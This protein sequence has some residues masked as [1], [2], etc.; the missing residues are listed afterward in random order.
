MDIRLI[1]GL[2]LGLSAL[3]C[4]HFNQCSTN[5]DCPQV[6][7]NMLYCTPDNICAAGTPA[8]SLCT[9]VYPPNSP[10]N[11]IVIG[12]LINTIS[13]NDQL[14]LLAFEEGIDEVNAVLPAGAQPL[15]L[16]ICEV[17]ATPDDPYKSMEVLALQQN[18]VAAVGPT[19]SSL[20]L[21]IESEVVT[22]GIPIMSPSATSPDISSYGTVNG[23]VNGLF[24]RVAPS[25]ALQGP[26]LAHQLPM[27]FPTTDKLAEMNVDDSYGTGLSS[28]FI[29]AFGTPAL[30]QTYEEPS[31][32]VRDPTTAIAAANAIISSSPNYVVAITNTYSD[33]VVEALVNLPTTIPIIMADG[34]LNQSVLN[35]IGTSGTA[36]FSSYTPTQMNNSLGR[37]TGTAPTTDFNNLTGT[38]AY[39]NF[40]ANFMAKWNMDPTD[41]IYTAYA[42]DAIYAVAIAIGAA[43]SNL[44]PA[45]VSGMLSHINE[46]N[47]ST[48]AC[49]ASG[50]PGQGNQA[51]V[52]QANYLSAKTK[53]EQGSGL[54][55]QGTTG[56]ICFSPHGD[57]VSGLYEKWSINIASKTF[58]AV[59]TM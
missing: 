8:A 19:S 50:S 46:V 40:V 54:V 57:R 56:T 3:G 37:I 15:A 36:P 28:A 18:A 7:G 12:A 2:A 23:P 13:G 42:Y 41:S 21:D 45:R 52:G 1:L 35:L 48:G 43:G 6:D 27:P 39:Q 33:L 9:Q 49:Q 51:V 11:A 29:S 53:V 25:D 20:V 34:A 24:Y 38:G 17:G 10:S 22:S 30:K 55:L 4:E 5:A 14:P 31:G 58:T 47:P 16:H 26:V 44:T 59:P 32:N